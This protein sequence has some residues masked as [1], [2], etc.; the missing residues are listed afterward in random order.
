MA[1]AEADVPVRISEHTMY[2]GNRHGPCRS[3]CLPR[4]RMP[5]W[6]LYKGTR[7]P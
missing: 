3:H 1:V 4:V 2:N 6:W 7:G 5:C